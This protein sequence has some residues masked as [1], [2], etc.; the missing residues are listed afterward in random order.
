MGAR[1]HHASHQFCKWLFVHVEEHGA[2]VVFTILIPRSVEQ[3][4]LAVKASQSFACGE[5]TERVI[6][7]DAWS[8]V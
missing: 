1:G 8:A 6:I 2:P 3:G 5:M 7:L 4:T